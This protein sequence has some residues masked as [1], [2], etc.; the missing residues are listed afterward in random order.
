MWAGSERQCQRKKTQ[1]SVKKHKAPNS[2]E[3]TYIPQEICCTDKT[4]AMH[5]SQETAL[6]TAK[7]AKMN[8]IPRDC[9][10]RGS[11]QQQAFSSTGSRSWPQAR[12]SNPT[13]QSCRTGVGFSFWPSQVINS[14]LKAGD[15]F[16]PRLAAQVTSRIARSM[17]KDLFPFAWIYSWGLYLTYLTV[18]GTVPKNQIRNPKTVIVPNWFNMNRPQKVSPEDKNSPTTDPSLSLPQPYFL[19]ISERRHGI[20]APD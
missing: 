4:E 14:H 7:S 20:S 15:L 13:V 18:E 16:I 2:F 5:Y 10:L 12:E 6:N 17:K 1:K 3:N 11:L 9:D 19:W 8:S